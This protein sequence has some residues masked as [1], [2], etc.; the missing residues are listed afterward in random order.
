MQSGLGVS[1]LRG[2]I[3][4]RSIT[5]WRQIKRDWLLPDELELYDYIKQHFR[6][7]G[8]LPDITAVQGEGFTLPKVKNPTQYYI[9]RLADRAVYNGVNEVYPE[10]GRAMQGRNVQQVKDALKRMVASTR[11]ADSMRDY[12]TMV[13]QGEA[14]L[15]DYAGAKAKPGLQGITTGDPILDEVTNG[16][17][18]G[19]VL[20]Y[21]GRPNV[22]KSYIL[23]STMLAG[24]QAGH[25]CLGVTME[26]Y[27]KQQALRM[28]AMMAKL[29]PD[30]IRK[31]Q[32]STYYGERM[33]RQT[34]KDFAKR[35]P[36][37]FLEGNFKKSVG[38]V[39]NF[40]QEFS[41]DVCYIDAGYL[42]SPEN[43]PKNW[44]KR[45]YQSAVMTE[46]K[47]MATDRKIPVVM[48]VQLNR[49]AGKTQGT[50]RKVLDLMHLAE[51][52]DI[53]RIAT[54]VVAIQKG[55]APRQEITRELQIIKNREGMLLSY[56]KNF[57]FNPMNFSQILGSESTDD[58][59]DDA[60][61]VN[62]QEAIN[63]MEGDGWQ[64]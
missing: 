45:D 9:D 23:A 52:D 48:T 36:F 50:K 32:L 2:V 58:A 28:S 13:E 61:A 20:V 15:V 11:V 30:L 33:L 22:G 56:H 60:P 19:D 51:T 49:E 17:Q 59:Q 18:P 42:L 8:T 38:D 5:A 57:L 12:T 63:T 64:R 39:D 25:P 6:S 41:P 21:A 55:A 29:N 24:W 7:Y 14:L 31:G 26:M 10:L 62:A 46:I 53:G 4:S 27:T 54:V 37:H 35:P 3:D 16:L 43:V 40:I 44:Q 47:A 1:A 34:I